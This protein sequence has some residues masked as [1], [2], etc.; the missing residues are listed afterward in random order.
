MF[1]SK[2]TSFR[3]TALIIRPSSGYFSNSQH[4]EHMPFTSKLANALLKMCLWCNSYGLV[5]P[6]EPLPLPVTILRRDSRLYHI[7]SRQTQPAEHQWVIENRL[8]LM[9]RWRRML[10]DTTI[11]TAINKDRDFR[12]LLVVF[13]FSHG[14][15]GLPPPF[16]E[17]LPEVAT[18]YLLPFFSETFSFLLN[19]LVRDINWS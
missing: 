14:P 15:L 13:L 5:L 3:K 18:A 17:T 11:N 6:W 19:F 7:P 8:W 9:G 12:L 10:H 2:F 16:S 1:G 4:P